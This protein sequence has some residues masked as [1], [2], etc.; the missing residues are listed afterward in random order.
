MRSDIVKLSG[1]P[2][3]TALAL[4]QAESVAAFFGMQGKEAIHLRL[5]AEEMMGMIRSL[6][7]TRSAEFWIEDDEKADRRLRLHLKAAV[8][9][10]TELRKELLSASTSGKNAAAKGFSGKLRDIFAR[11]IE[12][13]DKYIADYYAAGWIISEP[14]MYNMT[15]GSV[16]SFNRYRDSLG[17]EEK[18][19]HDELEKSIIAN[20]AD[21]VEVS[22]RGDAVEMIVYKKNA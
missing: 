11:A 1:D 22:I 7:G 20:L 8:G 13:E 15:T 12:P 2:S 17:P 5:L 14:E 21:E 16:W 3:D 18:E 9:M 10:N 4:K 6:T 19:E